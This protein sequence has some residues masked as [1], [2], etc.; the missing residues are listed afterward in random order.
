MTSSGA[1]VEKD[2]SIA[3]MGRTLEH[4]GVQMYKRR[5]AALAELVANAWDAGAGE[6]E[7][8]LPEPGTYDREQDE[9]TVRDDG[10]GM[11]DEGLQSDYL[12]IGRNRRAA[13]QAEVGGRKPM[14]RKGIGK[15]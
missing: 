8:T 15:L 4:L 6:V 10:A 1:P 9:I 12:V 5:D 3:V 14:G 11:T 2:F 7:I 13:G